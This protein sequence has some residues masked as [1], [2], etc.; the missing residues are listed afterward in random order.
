MCF[1]KQLAVLALGISL[2]HSLRRLSKLCVMAR[3][4]VVAA[5]GRLPV[6]LYAPRAAAAGVVG[7]MLG[8]YLRH[9]I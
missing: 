5:G 9:Q 4:V 2:Q 3:V 8:G 6:L 1:Q 7:L